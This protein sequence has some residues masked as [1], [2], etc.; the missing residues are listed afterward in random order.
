MSWQIKLLDWYEIN[1][2]DLPWRKT[3]DPY[4]IWLS[5][6]IM[7]Q[8][9]VQQGLPYYH[10]FVKAYPMIKDLAEAT[11]KE[12]LKRWEGLGYYS[13]ARNLHATAQFI[14]NEMNGTFPSTFDTIIQLKGIG[15]Y[16]AS[17]IASIA[18]GLPHAVVDGNVY[19]FYARFYGIDLPIN[20]TPAFKHFKE[21][22]Q[23]ALPAE[24]PGTFNQALME[25]GALQCTSKNPKCQTC[26]LLYECKAYAENEV[27]RWPIKTTKTKIK[28]RYFHYLVFE[29]GDQKKYLQQRQSSGI[30]YKLYEF[31]L[32]ERNRTLTSPDQ[33][34]LKTIGSYTQSP[35][36]VEPIGSTRLHK[37]SHQYIEIS[38][39]KVKTKPL[40]FAGFTVKEWKQLPFPIP[41]AHFL[42][43]TRA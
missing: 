40:Q 34:F 17:A 38:F 36:E 5:E 25:L 42:K 13:R 27:E 19:R 23:K 11:E 10:S 9:R 43:E 32:I 39:W 24:D 28:K 14:S 6:I 1:R 29:C 8:T 2:R 41:I 16:T 33:K 15:D 26:P 37:L 22:A 3:K 31:P 35:F 21:V 18:F 20:T 7:Q 12:V 30:W 4:P